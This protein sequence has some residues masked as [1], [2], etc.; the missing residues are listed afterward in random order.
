MVSDMSMKRWFKNFKH[1]L[2]KTLVLPAA[3]FLAAG[4]FASCSTLIGDTSKTGVDVSDNGQHVYICA[5]SKH[6]EEAHGVPNSI[7]DFSNGDENPVGRETWSLGTLILAG[8]HEALADDDELVA[9]GKQILDGISNFHDEAIS[10]GLE[11]VIKSC[12]NVAGVRAADPSH[13]G[14]LDYACALGQ[15]IDDEYGP[16]ETWVEIEESPTWYEAFS[17]AALTGAWNN[18]II[19]GQTEI[20]EAGD[21]LLAGLSVANTDTIDD[22]LEALHAACNE[23]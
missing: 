15:R 7:E 10:S 5:L 13:E 17:A 6:I 11:Q 19:D 3:L 4:L 16:A 1:T 2:S 9:A 14:Q 18:E 20:F 22:A 23:I 12:N 8:Q 21:E